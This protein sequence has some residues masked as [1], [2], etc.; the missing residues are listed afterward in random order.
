MRKRLGDGEPALRCA[1]LLTEERERDLVC[2][3]RFFR[4]RLGS[5]VEPAVVVRD[6]LARAGR[7]VVD[8]LAV[9]GRTIRGASSIVRSS[10]AR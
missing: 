2:G 4:Q 6:E 10:D 5:L 7:R 3:A 1:Q 9:S 8:R